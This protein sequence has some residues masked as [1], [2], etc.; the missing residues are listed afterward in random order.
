MIEEIASIARNGAANLVRR[1]NGSVRLTI[2]YE[3]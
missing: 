1:G 2:F 3:G